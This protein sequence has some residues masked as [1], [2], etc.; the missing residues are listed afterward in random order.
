MNAKQRY[1]ARLCN[2]FEHTFVFFM[3]INDGHKTKKMKS[4]EKDIQWNIDR[5]KKKLF[6]NVE[7]LY[8]C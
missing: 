6:N 2:L 5:V 4:R 7:L 1:I 3:A 8:T